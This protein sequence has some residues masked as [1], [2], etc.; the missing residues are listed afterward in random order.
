MDKNIFIL[1]F[2]L[3]FLFGCQSTEVK[4]KNCGTDKECLR[5]SFQICEK[6]YGTW[7]GDN[8]DI[9][10]Q[11][12]GNSSESCEVFISISESYLDITNKSMTC[13]I[14][15]NTNSDFSIQN[16]CRDKLKTFFN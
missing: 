14:S 10:A 4:G 5:S 12:K 13:V 7:K 15:N 6:A 9:E 2:L 8:G 3:I 16:D 1:G 11:I